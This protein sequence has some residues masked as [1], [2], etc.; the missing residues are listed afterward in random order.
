VLI[1]AAAALAATSAQAVMLYGSQASSSGNSSTLFVAMDNGLTESIVIDLGVRYADFLQSTA[2]LTDTSGALA[3]AGTLA[4][5]NFGSVGGNTRTLNGSS[6]A[7]SFDWSSTFATF[8]TNASGGYKWG[9]I[10]GD[11]VSSTVQS[12]TNTI[13][14]RNFFLTGSPT[15]ANVNALTTT[16]PMVNANTNLNNLIAANSSLGTHPT[17][18]GASVATTGGAFLNTVMKGT[19]GGATTWN[20]L[21]SVGTSAS[22]FSINNRNPPVIYQ[23]GTALTVVN[24]SGNSLLDASQAATFSFDGTTLTYAV[25]VPEPETYALMLAGVAAIGAFVRRRRAV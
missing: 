4:T 2:L 21:S 1:A 19:A 9:V 16:T 8:V 3:A 17:A 14:A 6:V 15:Q 24:G 10:A 20:Y 25:P 23:L 5:W 13:Q 12:S 11:D 18:T 7:G 22:V